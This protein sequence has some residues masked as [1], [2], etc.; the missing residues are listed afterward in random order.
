[1]KKEKSGKK[2]LPWWLIAG[3]VAVIVLAVASGGT[4]APEKDSTAEPAAQTE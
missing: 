4:A 3:I 1:M 2:R